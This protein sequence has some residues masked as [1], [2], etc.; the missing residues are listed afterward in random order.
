MVYMKHVGIYVKNL[1]LEAS[2]YKKVFG[3]VPVC[4]S[5]VQDD[6]L[7]NDIFDGVAKVTISKLITE[8]GK[9]IG[10]G[11]MVE[12]LQVTPFQDV[13]IGVADRIYDAGCM[14][15]AF[16][17][18]NIEAVTQNIKDNQGRQITAIH[19][20]NERNKCCICRDPEGNWLELIENL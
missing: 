7:I 8:R 10:I 4:E 12:L 1:D 17:V 18:Q 5:I 2:F 15:V 6:E 16:S 11:D 14:H 13:G 20:L 9:E 3:M 19:L